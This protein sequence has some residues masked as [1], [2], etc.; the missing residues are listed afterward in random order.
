MPD[1]KTSSQDL[2]RA[3]RWFAAFWDWMVSHETASARRMREEIVGPASGRVLEVG[4][5]TSASFPYYPPDA[6]VVATDPDAEMLKRA[7]RRLDELG[8]DNI[9]LHQLPAEDLP[10][11]DASFDHVVSC[12]VFCH[13]SDP[14]HALTET[15][16]L[17]RP[18]G[19]FRFMEHVRSDHRVW[20]RTQD[21]VN[22][23]WRRLLDA[24]CNVNRHTQ[25]TIEQAGLDIL[26]LKRERLFPPTSP[27][28][29]GVARLS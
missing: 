14:S 21:F 3:N 2:L 7:Q 11:A 5:G 15:R 9:D 27:G 18:E 4:C 13:V 22:P 17:L 24:G 25:Q 16:R 26:W 23:V 29:Y 20:G 10:F 6:Q 19:T 1:D 8:R 12:W 28:I